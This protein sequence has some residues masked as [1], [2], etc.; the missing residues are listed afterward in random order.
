M[1]PVQ[2]Q[3][4]PL[5][6]Q[7]QS[8]VRRGDV[9]IP[10]LPAVVTRIHE[11]LHNES[12]ADSHRVAGLVKSEPAIAASILRV[13]NSTAFGGL[14]PVG[15][16]DEGIERIGLRQVG[17]LVT[18]VGH[19]GHFESQDPE[20]ARLL[21]VLGDHAV[22]TALAARRLAAMNGGDCAEAYLAGLLHDSGKLLALKGVDWLEKRSRTPLSP[23]VVTQILSLLHTD[24]G[25]DTLT[26]W[27]IAVPVCQVARDHHLAAKPDDSPILTWVR[28][29]NVLSR[30]LGAH[31]QPDPSMNLIGRPEI[32]LLNLNDPELSTLLVD[33]EIEL[34]EV[35]RLL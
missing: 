5:A 16:L 12:A 26:A 29:G 24:L 22:T 3:A 27:K 18:A 32:E 35:R 7:V 8:A 10:P 34:D 28:A 33:L 25:H 15:E 14:S 9:H 30:K 20:R 1:I 11:L 31:P 13:A 17:A 21:R 4:T 2:A 23:A 19:K 6:L